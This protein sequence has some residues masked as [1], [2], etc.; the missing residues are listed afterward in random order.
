[1]L[2]RFFRKM[3]SDAAP[4]FYDRATHRVVPRN[5]SV[6]DPSVFG[7]YDLK[8]QRVVPVEQ[9]RDATVDLDVMMHEAQRHRVG[10]RYT[11]STDRIAISRQFIAPGSGLFLDACTSAVNMQTKSVA[12]QAGYEYRAIDIRGDGEQVLKEDLCQLSFHDSAVS[13][14]FSVDTLEHIENVDS[15]LSEIH[16]VLADHGLLVAHVPAYFFMRP[17]SPTIDVDNDPYG[18]VR[19]F[20]GQ[21]LVNRIHI[22]GLIPLRIGFFLDYGAALVCAAKNVSLHGP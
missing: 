13:M 1:M 6:Y 16:R 9:A 4:A 21:D 17:D 14:V 7:K 19:Y 2:K 15:A 10:G 12:E 5:A 20:S 3:S 8:Y 11:L 18:H 22:A